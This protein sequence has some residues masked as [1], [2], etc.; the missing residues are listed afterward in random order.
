MGSGG[1]QNRIKEQVFIV[2]A[3][4]LSRSFIVI[5]FYLISFGLGLF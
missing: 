4:L 2:I 5:R 1:D 3:S